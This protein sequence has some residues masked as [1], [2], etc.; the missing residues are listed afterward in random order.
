MGQLPI[1]A[2]YCAYAV[3]LPAQQTF[4]CVYSNY[5]PILLRHLWACHLVD[6]NILE[7]LTN[8]QATFS[9]IHN[10]THDGT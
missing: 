7:C 9:P 5:S 8:L 1:N 3:R 6:Y 10:Y 2:A 4:S